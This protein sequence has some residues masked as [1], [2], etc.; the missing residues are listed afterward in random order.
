MKISVNTLLCFLGALLFSNV[1]ESLSPR[2]YTFQLSP[3]TKELTQQ[4]V[5]S[6]FQDSNGFIWI[7]TQEGLHK[8]DGYSVTRFRASN[9]D[10]ASI[11]HQS[12]TDIVEDSNGF[13]WVSTAG[14][15]VNKYNPA[16]HKFS[17]IQA[18]TTQSDKHPLSNNIY[19]MYKDSDGFIWIAYEGG[20]GFSRFSPNTQKFDHFPPDTTAK[21]TRAVSFVETA[22]K[23]LWILI[24]GLGLLQLNRQRDF[25]NIIAVTTDV[26]NFT[27]V[28]RFS[29]L[30]ASKDGK[31]WISTLNGGL[32]KFNPNTGRFTRYTNE[33]TRNRALSDN[34]VYMS[35]ED[36]SNNVWVATRSG[37]SVWEPESDT[38]TW[39]NATN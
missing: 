21:Q 25:E 4:S 19:S 3:A 6:V 5:R 11:S 2:D 15:G 24:D 13:L 30:M 18:T 17:S 22:D 10:P 39:I 26:E 33:S 20:A 1:A 29:H 36:Q 34:T 7:L 28:T 14:G 31:L 35:I 16:N 8:F 38:F 37:V 23:K 27:G 32:I 9:R 12:T